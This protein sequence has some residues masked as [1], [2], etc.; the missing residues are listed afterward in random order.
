YKIPEPPAPIPTMEIPPV[1]L[2][3][4]T[5][6][7]DHLPP[8]KRSPQPLPMEAFDQKSGLIL[9]RT[10][11]I[12]HKS[13]SLT[14]TEPHDYALIFLNGRLIDTVFRDGG[15]WTVQLP[16]TDVKDPVLDILVEGMG[17]INF[18]QYMIDRKGITDRVTLNG[19][20]LMDWEIFSLPLDEQYMQ[21]VRGAG[22]GKGTAA[23]NGIFFKGN[24]D[25][26]ETADTYIDMSSFKKGVVWINGHNLGRY[27][28]VGPQQRLYCPAS[29]LKKGKNEVL[30]LDLHQREAATV[31]GT[32]T[33]E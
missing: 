22:E 23:G 10:K 24:F 21:Q 31:K 19:M 3:P 1:S 26:T 18:A 29:W 20:T 30:V 27:W 32:R 12:G 2:Q 11:L 17:H 15:K 7:W 4:Y 14:I 5:S 9:Y 33:L 8:A 6:V 13:G 16:K 25:L 28:Y